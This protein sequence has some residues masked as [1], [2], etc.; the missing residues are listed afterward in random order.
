[1]SRATSDIRKLGPVVA[2]ATRTLFASLLVLF[3]S[4]LTACQAP[5]Q[6]HSDCPSPWVCSPVGVCEPETV[7]TEDPPDAGDNSVPPLAD[8]ALPD[9]DEPDAGS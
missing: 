6:R 5:C 3:V 2:T 8:G 7:F 9:F 1:M 4:S